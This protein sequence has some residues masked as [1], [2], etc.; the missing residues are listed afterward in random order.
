MDE[1]LTA[2]V[3]KG[4]LTWDRPEGG[5][6]LWAQLTSVYSKTLLQE[7]AKQGGELRPGG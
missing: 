2:Y 6:Y 7:A 4:E 5:L 3:P 1:A